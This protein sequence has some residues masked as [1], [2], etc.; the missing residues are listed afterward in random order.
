MLR[1]QR[2]AA[3]VEEELQSA[4]V[5]EEFLLSGLANITAVAIVLRP[6]IVSRLSKRV[7][8]AAIGM[9]LRRYKARTK[10]TV[11]M[12]KRFPSS[13]EI[14]PIHSLIEIGIRKDLVSTRRA[15][16]LQ[17]VFT[18]S[19]DEVSTIAYGAYEIVILAQENHEKRIY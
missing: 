19:K 10:K 13:I 2:L 11:P 15:H 17:K 7:S 9:A 3:I 12:K 14:R 6:L 8:I 5:I 4:P 18:T 1:T 16:N